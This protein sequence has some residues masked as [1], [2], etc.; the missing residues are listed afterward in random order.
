MKKGGIK[1]ELTQPYKTP[2]SIETQTTGLLLK[3]V[4]ALKTQDKNDRLQV[5]F[6]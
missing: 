5:I 4:K 2:M 3:I 6:I 1:D